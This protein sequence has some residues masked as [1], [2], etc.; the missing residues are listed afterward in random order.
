MNRTTLL[1]L[2][3]ACFG[4][5]LVQMDVTIVNVA[6]PG[7]PFARAG[8]LATLQ[9]VVD[10]Y[11]LMFASF[12]LPAGALGARFG[13]KRA[14]L[15]GLASFAL[16]SLACSQAGSAAMLIA[17]RGLQ[18][19]SASLLVPPSLMLVNHAF[20]DAPRRRAHAVAIWTTAGG[21]ALAAGP[22]IGSAIIPWLGWRGIFL[23]NLPCCA[24]GAVAT[25]AADDT[26]AE[27][28]RP[29]DWPGQACAI[30]TV[31]LLTASLIASGERGFG[32]AWVLWGLLAALIAGL[33]FL[34]AERSAAA[35]VLPPALLA[36]S[37]FT[38]AVVFGALANACY[39][40]LLFLLTLF[41]QGV[42]GY[43]ASQAALAYLP[44]TATFI[45]SNLASGGFVVRY[46]ARRALIA[47]ASIAALGFGLIAAIDAHAHVAPWVAPFVLIPAGIG[48]AIPAMTVTVITSVPAER[49]GVATGALNAAR[50]VGGALGVAGFG[51]LAG[52]HHAG[53]AVGLKRA[54]M[55]AA[56]LQAGA[57]L[58][59]AFGTAGDRAASAAGSDLL[60]GSTAGK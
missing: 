35:P 60:D 46:G 44:L 25:L 28:N 40:G 54:A 16:A 39:F 7:L 53:V 45:V 9:W 32:D 34:L 22:L 56:A 43:T 11:A 37:R 26:R 4:F 41:L 57:A 31:V 15:G 20:S 17:A 13:A 21:V 5:F 36:V 51:A 1:T 49:V 48:L 12:L 55:L 29:F 14:Y 52:F 59:I 3:A 42:E 10:G 6:L 38:C 47:G 18:G 27:P 23:V 2:I 50:Q 33:L 58:L 19:V 8:S 24:L 30:A